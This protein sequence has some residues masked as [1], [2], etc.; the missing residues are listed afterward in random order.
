[1]EPVSA[2]GPVI[3]VA[4]ALVGLLAMISWWE[5]VDQTLISG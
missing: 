4:T 2:S 3:A 5:R 1:L